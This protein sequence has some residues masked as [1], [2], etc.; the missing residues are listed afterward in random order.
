MDMSTNNGSKFIFAD[1]RLCKFE[2]SRHS[3]SADA[4]C[5]PPYAYRQAGAY[6]ECHEDR[7]AKSALLMPSATPL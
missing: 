4:I 2:I 1:Y 6:Q 7:K 5:G 3:I